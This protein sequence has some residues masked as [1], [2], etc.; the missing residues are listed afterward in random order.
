M[1]WGGLMPAGLLD[2]ARGPAPTLS[3]WPGLGE[4]SRVGLQPG[5]S[6]APGGLGPAKAHPGP[7]PHT[8][9]NPNGAE[10]LARPRPAPPHPGGRW[11]FLTCTVLLYQET[12]PAPVS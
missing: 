5:A 3:G 4:Q 7:N 8:T 6:K 11:H 9:E 1:G 10:T 2:C 12:R